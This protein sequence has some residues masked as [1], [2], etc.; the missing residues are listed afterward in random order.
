MATRE[1]IELATNRFKDKLFYNIKLYK[2]KLAT[3]RFK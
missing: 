2:Y 1:N 3:N